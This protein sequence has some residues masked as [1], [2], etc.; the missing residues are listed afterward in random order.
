MRMGDEPI[1]FVALIFFSVA[2][3]ALGTIAVSN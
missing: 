1:G 3:K 2:P